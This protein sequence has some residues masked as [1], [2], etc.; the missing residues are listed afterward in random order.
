MRVLLTRA[1]EDSA[2]TRAKLEELGH[3]VTIAPVI[4]IE[5]LTAAWPG[6]VFD[7]VV[8]TSGHAFEQVR[9]RWGPS[10][11]ARRLLPLWVVG[12]RTSDAAE[13]AGFTGSRTV[14]ANAV[15]LALQVKKR[16]PGRLAYL[17][18]VHRKPDVET[19]LHVAG[20]ALE[21]IEVYTARSETKLPGPIDDALAEGNFDLSLHYSRRSAEIFADLVRSDP[22]IRHV[23]LSADVAEPLT[24]RGW[25][26]EIAHEPNERSL[27]DLLRP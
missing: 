13:R 2:R 8:A 23:C 26:V 21:T 9:A 11:E 6:G 25:T 20:H 22:P 18:G 1:A 14:A 27:L 12:Q 3:Q 16:P 15:M 5:A 10:P 4:A 17:A 7:G 24:A 19:A